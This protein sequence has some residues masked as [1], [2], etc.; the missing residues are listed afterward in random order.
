MK[1][2][3]IILPINNPEMLSQADLALYQSADCY[4]KLSYVDTALRELKSASDVEQIFPLVLNRIVEAEQAGAAAVVVYAFG[5]VAIKEGKDLVSI[6]VM[7]LGKA[8]VNMASLLC[9]RHY[10]VLP[11]MLGHAGFINAMVEE[12]GVGHRFIP[13]SHGIEV[14]PAQLKGNPAVLGQ[15]IE[16]ADFEIREKGVDTF[17]LGCGGFIGVGKKLE[18]ALRA[19]HQLAITVIDPVS[20]AL[21]LAKALIE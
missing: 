1:T 5:D 6:P 16:I 9:R 7:G 10:T 11:S 12:E 18:A 2:I 20:V 15:L 8:A 19:K 3:S 21:G 13:A 4:F 14:S 17:T